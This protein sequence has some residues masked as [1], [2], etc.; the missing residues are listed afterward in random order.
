MGAVYLATDQRFGSSV[1]LKETLV[2]GE[3][4]RRAFER[5]ARLLNTLQHAALPHVIDYFFEGEG[6]FLVMQFIPG[7]DLGHMLRRSG[8]PFSIDDVLKW[9]DQLLDL[10]DYLHTHE[11]AIVHRDIKPENLKLTQR[12]N[13]IL[14]DFGLAKG[15][16]EGAPGTTQATGSI[17]GY[18]PHYA[19][20]EQI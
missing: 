19:S 6:Q 10:L 5:E 20:L 16:A 7:E 9:A 17:L 2:A 15:L 13:V 4:L 1:A 3:P 8:G 12:G 11:P 18:T 14:L